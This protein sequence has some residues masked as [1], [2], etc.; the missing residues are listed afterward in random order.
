VKRL[1]SELRNPPVVPQ[2]SF[3][4]YW[5]FPFTDL[6]IFGIDPG[7]ETFSQ[8]SQMVNGTIGNHPADGMTGR[9]GEK[10]E[11]EEGRGET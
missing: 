7:S 1:G 5:G 11:E 8:I 4:P 2:E 10:L 3:P 9:E 6:E